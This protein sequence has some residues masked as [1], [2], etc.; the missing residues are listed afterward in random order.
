[1]EKFRKIRTVIL[2]LFAGFPLSRL[3][4]EETALIT[5]KISSWIRTYDYAL[6]VIDADDN[7]DGFIDY[8][9]HLDKDDEKVLEELDFNHDGEMDDFYFYLGGIM[10]KREID[11]NY[12]GMIDIWVFIKEGIYVV[13]FERDTDFDGRIDLVKAY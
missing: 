12:D 3:S 5:E 13:R 1:M 9:L 7:D 4:G 10:N 8:R 2:I 11:T 6:T